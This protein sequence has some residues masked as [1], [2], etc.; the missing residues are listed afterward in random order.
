MSC[1]LIFLSFQ[2]RKMANKRSDCRLIKF[3]KIQDI[4]GNLTFIEGR[5]H[6]PFKAERVYFI[7]DV[8]GGEARGEH[9]YKNTCEVAI[10]L[11]GSFDIYVDDGKEKRVFSL[12]RSCYGIYIPPMIWRR[13]ENFSTNSVCLAIASMPYLEE[14]YLRNYDYYQRLKLAEK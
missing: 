6:I 14:D 8:P 5:V 2:K 11:A 4:R 12:N 10:S 1:F 7:Y 3:P 9:A 13:M